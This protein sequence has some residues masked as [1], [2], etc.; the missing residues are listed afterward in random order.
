MMKGKRQVKVTIQTGYF[1]VIARSIAT[2]QST[3]HSDYGLF[4]FARN[5]ENILVWIVTGGSMA[6][7]QLVEGSL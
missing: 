2:K 3:F 1:I 7:N 5:D 4:R 6:R